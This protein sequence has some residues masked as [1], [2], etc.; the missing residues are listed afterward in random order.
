MKFHFT[1]YELYKHYETFSNVKSFYIPYYRMEIHL[2]AEV[3]FAIVFYCFD[4]L[5]ELPRFHTVKLN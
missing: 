3:N 2:L 5:V 1:E 4:R